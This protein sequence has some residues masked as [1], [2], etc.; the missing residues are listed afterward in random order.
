[1]KIRDYLFAARPECEHKVERIEGCRRH[2]ESLWKIKT[3][4]YFFMYM[5]QCSDGSFY[6]SHTDDIESRISAH[7]IGFYSCYTKSRLPI[8][9]V[10]VQTFTSRNEAFRAERKIKKWNREKKIA[11]PSASF[12]TLHFV[13]ALRTSGLLL[14]IRRAFGI[15]RYAPL[16]VRTQDERR[17]DNL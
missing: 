17:R 10:F 11:V 6:I 12:D 8:K 7:R 5:L 2:G 1:M 16:C 3:M 15:P 9:V 4:E 14:M 13:F